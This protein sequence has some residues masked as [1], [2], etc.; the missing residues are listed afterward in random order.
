MRHNK[1]RDL[2]AEFMR[3]VCHDVKVEPPLLPLA[4]GNMTRVNTTDKARLDGKR[5]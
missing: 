5:S 4:T 3:E 1:V 2:E